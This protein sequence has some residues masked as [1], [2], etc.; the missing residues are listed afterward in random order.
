MWCGLKV[1]RERFG[2]AAGGGGWVMA[3]WVGRWGRRTVVVVV[4][5]LLAVKSR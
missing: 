4:V 2:K 3:A 5:V 1:V